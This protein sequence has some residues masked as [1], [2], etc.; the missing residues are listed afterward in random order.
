VQTALVE[1]T[2]TLSYAWAQVLAGDMD[3]ICG[4][5]KEEFE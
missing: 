5:L 4:G 3:D 2:T 1:A